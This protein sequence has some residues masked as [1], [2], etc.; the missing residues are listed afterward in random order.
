M[1]YSYEGFLVKQ[2]LHSSIEFITFIASAK[3]VYSWSHADSIIIDKKGIQRALVK[4]RWQKISKFFESN[5]NNI[6]PNSVIIACDETVKNK[7]LISSLNSDLPNLKKISFTDEVKENTFIIDGQH[8]LKGI[9]EY[10][11]KTEENPSVE[12]EDIKI[13]V[14]LFLGLEKL[15]RAFQFITI[16]NKAHKVPVDNIKALIAD[17]ESVEEPLKERLSTASIT[18]GKFSTTIDIFNEN[19]ESPFYKLIDWPNN[20]TGKKLIKPLAIENSLKSIVKFFPELNLDGE[21]IVLDIM[22]KIWNT[23][24]EIYTITD[25]NIDEFTNLFT[26]TVIIGLTEFVAEKLSEKIIMNITGAPIDKISTAQEITRGIIT[27]IPKEFWTKTWAYKSLDSQG[28]RKIIIENIFHIKRNLSN[29][30]VWSEKVKLISE[31]F[32]SED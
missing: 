18:A 25:N 17:F 29:A 3:D 15:E 24:K 12:A 1:N 4:S 23:I 20:R 14:T 26:K 5:K 8:R 6:I 11:K 9:S 31:D 30:R 2:R 27:G 22:Y 32:I 21:D 16:N 10:I 28:G 7:F 13:V 19:K